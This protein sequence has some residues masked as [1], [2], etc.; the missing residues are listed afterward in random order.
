M[1][2][3]APSGAPRARARRPSRDDRSEPGD[4]FRA[5]VAFFIDRI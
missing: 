3:D 1:L 2:D 5:F 4:S